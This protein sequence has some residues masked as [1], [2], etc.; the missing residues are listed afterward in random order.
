M[1]RVR[2]WLAY[3]W[4]ALATP[5]ILATFVGR[6]FFARA[7]AEGTGV[8]VSPWI[9]GGELLTESTRDGYRIVIR[10]PV[11][12]GLLGPRST[13]FVQVEWLPDEGRDLPDT[14]EAFVDYDLD[15]GVDFV[16]AMN[17][18]ENRATLVMAG[19]AVMGIDRVYNLP[20]DRVVRVALNREP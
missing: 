20:R 3:T 8:T 18:R 15:G 7:L 1:K 14:L 2:S 5:L 10:Q 9:T 19:G 13:G 17:A 16:V 11:F 4:V 12:D 6:S